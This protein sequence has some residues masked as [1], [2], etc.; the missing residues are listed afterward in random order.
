MGGRDANTAFHNK[1]GAY[2]LAVPF[3]WSTALHKQM[4]MPA[5]KLTVPGEKHLLSAVQCAVIK[6]TDVAAGLCSPSVQR[7]VG[8]RVA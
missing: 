4:R 1:K 7:L 3:P 2:F 8:K 5:G 6:A